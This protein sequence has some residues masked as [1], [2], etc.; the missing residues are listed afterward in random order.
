MQ[1]A[2]AA[3]DGRRWRKEMQT[4]GRPAQNRKAKAVGDLEPPGY[5]RQLTEM[6]IS[7]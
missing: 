1:S 3:G 6:Q 7:R 2:A 5:R 4:F